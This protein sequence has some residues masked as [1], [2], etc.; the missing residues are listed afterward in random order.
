VST[1]T[2]LPDA[3]LTAPEPVARQL[4][5]VSTGLAPTRAGAGAMG[6]TP[7]SCNLVVPTRAREQ[8]PKSHYV[9]LA[10]R[11]T[12]AR[13]GAGRRKEIFLSFIV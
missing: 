11:C 6:S 12:H 9:T 8:A 13:A 2:L 1:F 3:P 4:R 7:F 5:L 10:D